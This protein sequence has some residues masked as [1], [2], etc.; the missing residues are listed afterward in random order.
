MHT[1][2]CI[3]LIDDNKATNFLHQDLIEETGWAREIIVRKN[4][5]EGLQYITHPNGCSPEVVLVDINMPVMD[6]FDFL[7]GYQRLTKQQAERPLVILLSTSHN[8]R[9][10][11]RAAQAGVPYL[12]K[13]LQQ[14]DLHR[15]ATLYE[16]N[17]KR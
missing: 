13:P 11:E 12:T 7:E 3:L 1:F 2:N 5:Q 6:G 17:K 10:Q 4:G 15:I 14:Q 8:P 16:E 9:D